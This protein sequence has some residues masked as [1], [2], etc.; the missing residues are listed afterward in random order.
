MASRKAASDAGQRAMPRS[1]SRSESTTR[2]AVKDAG[3]RIGNPKARQGR[4]SGNR[5]LR[6]ETVSRTQGNRKKK[7]A[8]DARKT[9]FVAIKKERRPEGRLRQQKEKAP[10]YALQGSCPLR[11]YVGC[12]TQTLCQPETSATP[13]IGT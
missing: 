13:L 5:G 4:G 3:Q 7:K 12:R 9:G 11:R 8:T 1:V 2:E 10:A 6:P